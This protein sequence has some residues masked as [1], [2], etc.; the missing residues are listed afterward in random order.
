MTRR[1]AARGEERAGFLTAPKALGPSTAWPASSWS[2]DW[3][4]TG[5]RAGSFPPRSSTTPLPQVRP[6]RRPKGV[7]TCSTAAAASKPNRALE[8]MFWNARG[9]EDDVDDVINFME[10]RGISVG[11]FVETRLFKKSL[12]R[13]KWEW[14]G[15][16]EH[17]P[18]LGQKSPRL[19]LGAFVDSE[20]HPGSYV[21]RK[22]EFT[23]WVCLKG[24]VQDLF[25]GVVYAAVY[26]LPDRETAF[27]ELGAGYAH[28]R[29]K[30][31]VVIGGDFNSRC[32]MNGDETLSTSG[33]QLFGFCE[34]FSLTIVNALAGVC[35]G[36]FTRIQGDERSTIDYVLVPTLSQT[37]IL[38]LEIVESSGLRSD[39]RPLVARSSWQPKTC[40]ARG[41]RAKRYA[42]HFKWKKLAGPDEEKRFQEVLTTEMVQWN[43]DFKALSADV[44]PGEERPFATVSFGA[45]LKSFNRAAMITPGQ[46]RVGVDSRGWV[47]PQLASMFKARAAATS[48]VRLSK[49][50]DKPAVVERDRI[51]LAIKAC[52]RQE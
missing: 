15:A 51:H 24:E 19:G 45:W 32:G 28:F 43:A 4:W 44:S 8:L 26:N 42:R 36:N 11:C 10:E 13:G 21:A 50:A 48:R 41:G 47:T 22:G 30:G 34:D 14:H 7:G 17:L 38:S 31:I 6:R 5:F 35:S 46:K 39:H 40:L 27:R 12:S 2:E 20:R 29:S 37:S 33:R 25:I 23:M 9:I 52:K 1:G 16:A 3:Q 49:G 18:N